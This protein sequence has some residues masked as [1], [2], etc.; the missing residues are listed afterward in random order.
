MEGDSLK[1]DLKIDKLIEAFDKYSEAD[2]AKLSKL[3][4][5][6]NNVS[7]LK[8]DAGDIQRLLFNYKMKSDG[9]EKA[10]GN[11]ETAGKNYTRNSSPENLLILLSFHQEVVVAF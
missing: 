5:D 8:D 1:L 11:Y 4:I 3:G 2:L 10:V 9:A 6:S 7:T